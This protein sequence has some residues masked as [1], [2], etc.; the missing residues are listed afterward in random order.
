MPGPGLTPTARGLIALA[1][2]VAIFLGGVLLLADR[3][4][5]LAKV[6]LALPM[7]VVGVAAALAVVRPGDGWTGSSPQDRSAPRASAAAR[8]DS[9]SIRRT[10]AP[11]TLGSAVGDSTSNRRTPR[12]TQPPPRTPNS[13]TT[14]ARAT[15][16]AWYF[17]PLLAAFLLGG[18]VLAVDGDLYGPLKAVLL[19]STAV[20]TAVVVVALVRV[21]P[22][23]P[24][25][26]PAPR[27]VATT[28]P[29]SAAGRLR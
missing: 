14:G 5:I 16:G 3:V 2:F 24:E 18:L 6:V 19:V 21:R 26:P 4:S 28:T 12:R 29:T 7:V 1:A 27:S 25:A 17:L 20:L 13:A 15:A 11:A 9:T 10:P 8:V 22:P 23:R